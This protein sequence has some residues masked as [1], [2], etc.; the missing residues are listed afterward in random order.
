MVAV[1]RSQQLGQLT[2]YVQNKEKFIK[3]TK[4]FRERWKE[5]VVVGRRKA[6]WDGNGRESEWR[7][8]KGGELRNKETFIHIQ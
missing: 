4:H 8:R 5:A 6:K 2:N 7:K 3:K 1:P